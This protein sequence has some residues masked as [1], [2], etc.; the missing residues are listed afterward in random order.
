M[1]T[2]FHQP[3]R[4]EPRASLMLEETEDSFVFDSSLFAL[5]HADYDLTSNQ[6]VSPDDKR[7]QFVICKRIVIEKKL[8]TGKGRCL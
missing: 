6:I 1:A 4:V 3:K 8:S 5:S 7:H 2:V